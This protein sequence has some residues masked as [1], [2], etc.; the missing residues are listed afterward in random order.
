M[1]DDPKDA[2]DQLDEELAELAR[3]TGGT[4]HIYPR[5]GQAIRRVILRDLQ[6]DGGAQFEAAQLEDDGTLRITGHDTGRSVSDFFGDDITSYEWVYVVPPDR[7]RTLLQALG[8]SDAEDDVLTA[9]AAYHEQHGGRISAVLKNP[10][11]CAAF[12]NWH[13]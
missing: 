13:S 11:V 7:V 6:T 8:A 2:R 5:P 10:P 9:L 3:A 1:A 4:L 12:D